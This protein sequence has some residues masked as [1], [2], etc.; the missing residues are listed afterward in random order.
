MNKTLTPED[1]IA[2]G[3]KKF[4]STLRPLAAYGLQK[5]FDDEVGKRYLYSPLCIDDV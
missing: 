3:Y 1:W 4:T 2:Q 5:R